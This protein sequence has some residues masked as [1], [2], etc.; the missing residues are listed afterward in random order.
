MIDCKLGF[1]QD[2]FLILLWKMLC[3]ITMIFVKPSNAKATFLQSTSATKM[4]DI[5]GIALVEYSLMCQGLGHFPDF[6]HHFLFA[7][8]ASNSMRVKIVRVRILLDSQASIG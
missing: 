2:I 3:T 5:H 1:D 7:K 4:F 6:L 8:L